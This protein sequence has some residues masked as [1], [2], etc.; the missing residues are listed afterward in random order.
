M[1]ARAKRRVWEYLHPAHY[2]RATYIGND[3]LLVK[4]NQCPLLVSSLDLSLMP[5]LALY[6]TFEDELVHWLTEHLP[7][8]GTFV[9]VG[10]NIGWFTVIGAK[11]V[12]STGVV[13]SVEADPRNCELLLDNISINYVAERVS[14]LNIAAWH[15]AGELSFHRSAKF[16][17][18]GSVVGPNE[19]Y[20][21][22]Y[23]GDVPELI[24]VEAARLDDVLGDLATIDVLK[25]DIEGA[26]VDALAGMSG[27][28][29]AGRVRSLVL[30]INPRADAASWPRLIE[31]LRAMDHLGWRAVDLGTGGSVPIETLT[32]GADFP[33]VVLSPG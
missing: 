4:S 16:H 2:P 21:R 20:R 18:N 23:P 32:S 31:W 6:G 30:E 24:T 25:M 7:A 17:G 33:N 28:L 15:S 27:L 1:L 26:E 10:A 22:R 19:E 9:D 29:A 14:V 13:V 3:R 11:A 8:G 5:F 12:G